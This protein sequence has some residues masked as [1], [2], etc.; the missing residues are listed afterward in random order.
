MKTFPMFLQ[1]AGRHVVIVGGG[2][3]AAQKAR[4]I[5]KTE[6]RIVLVAPELDAELS[7][8]VAQGRAT[9]VSDLSVG[10]FREAALVFVATG[11]VGLDYAAHALA[12]EAG[13]LVNVVDRPAL[14]DATTPSIV[15]RDPVVVAISTEGTAPVLARQIKS[16][17]EMLLEPALGDL[18]A[19]AGRLR[20]EV[21]QRIPQRA[22]RF[23]W[24]WVFNGPPRQA[25]AR[26]A[27]RD[28]ATLVKDALAVGCTPAVQG[29]IALVGAGPGAA[30]LLT[31]RALRLLQEA[32]VIYYDRLVDPGV[33]ELARRD[34]E[35]VF[36]GK[37]VGACAWPQD[38]INA[39]I[40]AAARQGKKVVR[41]KSGDPGIFGRLTEEL[42]AAQDADIPIQIVPGVTAASCAAAS[43]GR[44]LTERGMT[45]RLMLATAACKP[46]DPE[47]DWAQM[48]QPGTSLA[49][50]MGVRQA[51]SITQSLRAAR[52]PMSLEVE[53]VSQASTPRE[54]ITRCQLESLAETIHDEKVENPAVILVKWPKEAPDR[55]HQEIPPDR[56]MRM[57]QAL[58]FAK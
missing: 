24:D 29:A 36:V 54:K 38:R 50:Y 9:Q 48:L 7:A 28:A 18:A 5:L 21:A 39:V 32:D 11:C 41:L 16:K 52:V 25:M 49:I 42:R 44:G 30:D 58:C 26:G 34:A 2:E 37:E 17:M 3:Q 27:E 23:F 43:L 13:A 12:K 45:D 10:V 19:L 56:I 40:V 47:P 33:L 20:P 46:G 55:K 22:R 35:R 15:D 8:L 51:H 14:C 4:L 31:L 6:A 53:I 57:E 1:M